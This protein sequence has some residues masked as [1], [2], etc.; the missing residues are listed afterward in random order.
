MKLSEY[1]IEPQYKPGV[2]N[3]IAD[4]LSRNPLPSASL[5]VTERQIVELDGTIKQ[6]EVEDAQ[7]EDATLQHFHENTFTD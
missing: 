7:Y 1:D 6:H 4:T 3:V 5:V 2:D